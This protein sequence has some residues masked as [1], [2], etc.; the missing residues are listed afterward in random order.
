MIREIIRPQKPVIAV[1]LPENMVG[2]TIE[3]IA[4]EINDQNTDSNKNNGDSYIKARFI[5]SLA[6]YRVNLSKFVF[7]R[8]EANNYD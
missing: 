2:K 7:N 8:D 4:F 6:G 5:E 3:F 1:H